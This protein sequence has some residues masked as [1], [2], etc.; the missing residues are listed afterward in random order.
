MGV[1]QRRSILPPVL[2]DAVSAGEG[3][4]PTA[5]GAEKVRRNSVCQCSRT[6]RRGCGGENHAEIV[7]GAVTSWLR[8]EDDGTI[9]VDSRAQER[10]AAAPGPVR[11]I[12][13]L[14]LCDL[15][16][17]LNLIVHARM[18]GVL[19]VVTSS[20]DRTLIF[21][22]GDLRGTTSTRVGERLSEVMVRMGLLKP[23][24]MEDL[25]GNSAPGQRIGRLAVERGLMTERDVWDVM[26]EQVTM[27]FQAIML[28]PEG[29]FTFSEGS[30]EDSLT[31][32]GLSVAM[33]LM[34]G[35][36]R[37]DEMK[38]GSPEGV[39]KRLEQI[40]ADFNAGFRDIFATAKKHGSGDALKRASH[41]AFASDAF[42]AAFFDG[43]AFTA[44][45]EVPVAAFLDRFEEAALAMGEDP[46]ALLGDVLSKAML[47]LLFVAGEHLEPEVHRALHARAK[48]AVGPGDREHRS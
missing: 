13:D 11:L 2:H 30:V 8:I 20:G 47:F 1:V 26:Q 17:I 42:Q 32:P 36:R 7:D 3:V 38:A 41:S 33:L 21:E 25:V 35:L 34:E 18:S 9:G 45:G 16:D 29:I 39:R 31:V 46:P 4:L 48:T 37:I 14:S 12:G 40:L 22:D 44:T 15:P 43:I 6:R 10:L 27:I 24:V 23:E 5:Q 28:E 19:G